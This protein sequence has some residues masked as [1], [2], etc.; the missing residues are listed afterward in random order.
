MAKTTSTKTKAK[1]M[2]ALLLKRGSSAT[3]TVPN[4]RGS[5]VK[6]KVTITAHVPA[7]TDMY[8]VVNKLP[9]KVT[10]ELSPKAIER[11][12]S[13]TSDRNRYLVFWNEKNKFACPPAVILN[14]INA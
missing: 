3:Y 8:S 7:G 14:K 9:R 4:G 11:I 13:K 2:N 6:K 5:M 1:D 10:G 12:G